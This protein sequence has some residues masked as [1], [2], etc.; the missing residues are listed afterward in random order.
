METK[1]DTLHFEDIMVQSEFE[2][3]PHDPVIAFLTHDLLLAIGEDPERQGLQRTPERVARMYTEILSGYR[4]NPVELINGAIFE[5]DYQDMVVVR[6]LEFHSLCEHHLLPFT[7]K[8]HVA[9]IPDG[10]IIG[11]SKIPRLVEMYARRLQVQ[12]RMTCEVAETLQEILRPKGVAVVLEAA[13]MC[14]IMRGV[15]QAEASM[16]TSAFLGKFDENEKLRAEFMA[17]LQR[18]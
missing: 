10:N 9:Y 2:K 8:A 17:H 18:K 12:E 5:S 14:A 15:K 3:D 13:H 4:T 7:G 11:L 16:V 6:D 1:I